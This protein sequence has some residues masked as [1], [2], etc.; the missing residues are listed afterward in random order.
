MQRMRQQELPI[1]HFVETIP[2][3][4]R[5]IP[6]MELQD[7]K[8][9]LYSSI[10]SVKKFSFVQ[11]SVEKAKKVCAKVTLESRNFSHIECVYGLTG[12]YKHSW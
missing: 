4:L 10:G 7:T 6:W 1:I 11:L 12:E 3:M 9:V 5:E 2:S 8:V